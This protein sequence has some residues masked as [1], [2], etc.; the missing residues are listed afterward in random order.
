MAF[1]RP[2][3]W[4]LLMAG[5]RG[6]LPLLSRSVETRGDFVVETLAFDLGDGQKMRGFVARPARAGLQ[7]FPEAR[8]RKRHSTLLFEPWPDGATK[9]L[10]PMSN[11]DSKGE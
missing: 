7:Q 5:P 2:R 3:F 6:P 11:V 8:P 10:K 9:R 1:S 4:E